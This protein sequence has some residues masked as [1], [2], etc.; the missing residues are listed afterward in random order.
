MAIHSVVNPSQKG[1]VLLELL[2]SSLL[3]VGVIGSLTLLLVSSLK[4]GTNRAHNLVLVESVSS[5]VQ[6]IKQDVQRAGYG[7]GREGRATLAGIVNTVYVDKHLLAY[8]YWVK[9]EQAYRHVVFKWQQT[10]GRQRIND[11]QSINSGERTNNGQLLICEKMSQSALTLDQAKR[12]GRMG[13][14]FNLFDPNQ[15]GVSEFELAVVPFTESSVS[16]QLVSMSIS[17]YLVSNPKIKYDVNMLVFIR[18]SQ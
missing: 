2:I 8:R 15:V 13:N 4:V 9:E 7:S 1:A 5:V 16:R 12:S 6:Q 3:S 10:E 17:S 18:N 11:E 14:C